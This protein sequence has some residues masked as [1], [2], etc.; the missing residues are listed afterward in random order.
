MAKQP[1]TATR[2]SKPKRRAKVKLT[3]RTPGERKGRENTKQALMIEML[4]REEGATI[5]HI[6][7]ATGWQRHTVRGAIAGALKKKLGL[8][9]ESEKVEVCGRVYRIVDVA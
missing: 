7:E 5:D 8:N 2:A 1:K 6:A 9:I 4:R 3:R